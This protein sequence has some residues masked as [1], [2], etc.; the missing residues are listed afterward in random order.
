MVTG[1]I[2]LT[3]FKHVITKVK[4][5]AGEA[6]DAIVIPLDANYLKKHETNGSFYFNLVAWENKK[7]QEHSTHGIKQS[8]NKEQMA[9][10]SAE[11]KNSQPFFGNLKIADN[12][13]QS[14]VNTSNDF[15]VGAGGDDMP[16]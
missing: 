1:S 12:V 14:V 7:P 2:N 3:A 9:S 6:V 4:N 5:K 15:T 11:E 10:F 8:F 13:A 16:F